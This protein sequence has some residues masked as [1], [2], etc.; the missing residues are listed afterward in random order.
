MSAAECRHCGAPA[1]T[2]A[3]FCLECGRPLSAA[4]ASGRRI[5]LDRFLLVVALVGA[6]GLGLLAAGYWA[7][8]VVVVLSAVILYLA[9][10]ELERRRAAR[11]TVSLRARAAVAGEA[12]AARSREQL[13]VFRAR[14]ELAE[15]DAQRARAFHELG[16]AVFYGEEAAAGSARATIASLVEQ[17]REKESEIGRL[18]EETEQRVGRARLHVQP[19]ERIDAAAHEPT[20]EEPRPGG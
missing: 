6:G 15:L 17:M 13:E 8:G 11:R 12:V 19:S 2:E 3:R 7:W 9:R 10:R 16:R 14:R 20:P 4:D 18:R 5:R 1:P